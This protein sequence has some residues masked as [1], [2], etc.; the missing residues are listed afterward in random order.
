M[1]GKTSRSSSISHLVDNLFFVGSKKG[2]S[3]IVRV[4]DSGGRFELE[5]LENYAN[6]GPITDF[7]PIV[8][9]RMNMR[10][11]LSCSG[12]KGDSTIR[13]IRKGISFMIE[14]ECLIGSADQV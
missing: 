9:D 10:E 6:I 12:F 3:S 1:L 5:E 4:V 8:S 14:A 2:D 7:V 11:I 13:H